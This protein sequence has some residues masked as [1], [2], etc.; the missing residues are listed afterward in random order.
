MSD[1]QA[2]S[3]GA[4]LVAEN[5]FLNEQLGRQNELLG[6]LLA[7]Q[8]KATCTGLYSAEHPGDVDRAAHSRI[9]ENQHTRFPA[10]IIVD[11]NQDDFML[12]RRALWKAGDAARVW[13]AQNGREALM[14]LGDLELFA[15]AICVVIDVRLLGADGF[16]LFE[17]AKLRKAT[18]P[19]RFVFLTGMCDE[20][21][22]ANTAASVVTA[23]AMAACSPRRLRR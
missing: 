19:I 1:I 21:R 14:I 4:A 3:V 10:L 12:L 18:C 17:Q 2:R 8:R 11:D 22:V 16:A 20:A 23:C 15:S 13:W 9:G 5:Q 7:A 6:D